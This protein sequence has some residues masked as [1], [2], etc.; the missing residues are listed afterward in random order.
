MKKQINVFF[1]FFMLDLFVEATFKYRIVGHPVTN[2]LN[3]FL[4]LTMTLMASTGG[5]SIPFSAKH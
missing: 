2:A 4:Q 1:F 3:S 5:D